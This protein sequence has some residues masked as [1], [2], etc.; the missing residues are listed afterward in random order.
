MYETTGR[1]KCSLRLHGCWDCAAGRVTTF[2]T[3]P[4]TLTA[5]PAA[6][7]H[8]HPGAWSC[9]SR[10]LIALYLGIWLVPSGPG[11]LLSYCPQPSFPVPQSLCHHF[12]RV[13]F[14]PGQYR[15]TGASE[16]R[17]QPRGV[18][19]EMF[20]RQSLPS[21]AEGCSQGPFTPGVLAAPPAQ[22]AQ[23]ELQAPAVGGWG[24]WE[25]HHFHCQS[26]GSI[27]D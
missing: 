12:P 3:F 22:E 19:A 20:T 2:L 25:G 15:G 7:G 1:I 27:P 17:A 5:S 16:S 26:P 11:L 14:C 13:P 23:T 4:R 21:L 6:A 18:R 10:P 9:P 8:Y 24:L